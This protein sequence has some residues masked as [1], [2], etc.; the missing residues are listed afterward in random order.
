MYVLRN[1]LNQN[2]EP[3]YMYLIVRLKRQFN[4]TEID[5]IDQLI[6]VTVHLDC[7]ESFENIL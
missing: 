4:R 3:V 5:Q 7:V 6:G 1:V 2:N